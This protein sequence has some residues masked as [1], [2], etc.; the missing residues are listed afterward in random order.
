M[1]GGSPDG[2]RGGVGGLGSSGTA[3][4]SKL[5]QLPDLILDMLIL[6]VV[7]SPAHK[8]A[9]HCSNDGGRIEVGLTSKGKLFAGST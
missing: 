5:L 3:A 6:L 1:V 8:S 2:G 9:L 4:I 7:L